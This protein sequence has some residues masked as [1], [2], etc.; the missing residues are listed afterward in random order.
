MVQMRPYS[1]S[2]Q[3][4]GKLFDQASRDSNR[5][6]GAFVFLPAAGLE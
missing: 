6:R 1:G 5:S 3:F 4:G 2:E